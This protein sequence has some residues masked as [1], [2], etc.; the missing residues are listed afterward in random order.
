LLLNLFIEFSQQAKKTLYL[1]G[2]FLS[3]T[4]KINIATASNCY[5]YINTV[6]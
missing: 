2:E 5:A 6:S 1:Q 3:D 4:W